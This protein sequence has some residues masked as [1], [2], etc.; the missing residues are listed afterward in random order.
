VCAHTRIARALLVHAQH[1]GQVNAT[2]AMPAARND[3]RWFVIA[4]WDFSVSSAETRLSRLVS[5]ILPWLVI[6]RD[7]RAELPLAGDH[8]CIDA[9]LVRGISPAS[10][11]VRVSRCKFVNLTDLTPR[12]I[13]P[14]EASE[15]RSRRYSAS[16]R[17]TCPPILTQPLDPL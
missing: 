8:P 4:A 11:R 7:V 5:P 15:L 1:S 17:S 9:T 14:P 10:S 2:I 16:R 3:H 6:A 12:P 13:R